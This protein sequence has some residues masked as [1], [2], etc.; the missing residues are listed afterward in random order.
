M[1]VNT[2][3]GLCSSVTSAGTHRDKVHTGVISV[4][5]M[6]TCGLSS[7]LK[8]ETFLEHTPHLSES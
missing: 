5:A 1:L 7:K 8:I 4:C 3:G 6:K 2:T